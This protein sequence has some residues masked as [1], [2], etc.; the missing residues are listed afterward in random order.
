MAIG[1]MLGLGFSYTNGY[2]G[3]AN[4]YGG[5]GGRVKQRNSVQMVQFIKT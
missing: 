4:D 2:R 3:D 1:G 5:R